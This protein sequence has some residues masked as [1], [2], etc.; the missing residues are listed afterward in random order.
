M[1]LLVPAGFLILTL[2]SGGAIYIQQIQ[3]QDLQFQVLTVA[4][5]E[6]RSQLSLRRVKA[7]ADKTKRQSDLIRKAFLMLLDALEK[8]HQPSED[9][10]NLNRSAGRQGF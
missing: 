2:L 4:R 8:E 9:P 10:S 1:K 7:E 5:A 3:I 6:Q